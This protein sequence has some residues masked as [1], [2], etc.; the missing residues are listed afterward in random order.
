MVFHS[1]MMIIII[2]Y[3]FVLFFLGGEGA[4]GIFHQQYGPTIPASQNRF[5]IFPG[6]HGG[7]LNLKF[8]RVTPLFGGGAFSRYRDPGGGTNRV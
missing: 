5:D 4:G 6:S 3:I 1:I 8:L 2:L 7:N